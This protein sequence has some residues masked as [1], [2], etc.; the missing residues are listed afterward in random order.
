MD[1]TSPQPGVANGHTQQHPNGHAQ[2]QDQALRHP[3]QH[4]HQHPNRTP[5]HPHQ[6]THPEPPE[7]PSATPAT[8]APSTTLGHPHQ[9]PT[10]TK[11]HPTLTNDRTQP[12]RSPTDPHPEPPP[13]APTPSETPT[14][15][16]M[17]PAQ[18]PHQ[19]HHRRHH[20]L[21]NLR[22]TPAVPAPTS[23]K[24]TASNTPSPASP[25]HQ[26]RH[27]QPPQPEDTKATTAGEPTN[28]QAPARGGE[29]TRPEPSTGTPSPPKRPQGAIH[30]A[31]PSGTHTTGA[32][33]TT[34]TH[35]TTR[36]IACTTYTNSITSTP[37]H[38]LHTL[39]DR[40]TETGHRPAL[41]TSR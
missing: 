20:R 29:G 21:R 31:I 14:P 7:T 37:H 19:H 38:L 26:L 5:Q 2:P 24:P 33:N 15:P 22:T 4:R 1:P 11:R 40:A 27:R 35:D 28:H 23:P 25:H 9:Q 8:P 16:K 12:V 32:T 3:H 30:H 34:L 17:K 18:H 36:S 6:R 13:P 41:N 39:P 10:N